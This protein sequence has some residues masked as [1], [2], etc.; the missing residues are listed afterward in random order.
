MD[1]TPVNQKMKWHNGTPTN[2]NMKWNLL[3][4]V[5]NVKGNISCYSLCVNEIE[6]IG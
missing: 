6:K 2:Q 1:G 3:L 5:G 4:S